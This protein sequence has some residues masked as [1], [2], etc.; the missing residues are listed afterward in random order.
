[1]KLP[2]FPDST[3]TEW[4]ERYESLRAVTAGTGLLSRAPGLGMHLLLHYGVAGWMQKWALT[5]SWPSSNRT[6]PVPGP[7]PIPGQRAVAVLLAEMTLNCLTH[8]THTS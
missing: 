6:E 1:M 7:V 5:P 4:R 8:Y 2:A 3:A